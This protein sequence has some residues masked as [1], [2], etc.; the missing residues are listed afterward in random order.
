MEE[1][2]KFIVPD[3]YT[4]KQLRLKGW[5]KWRI[6]KYVQNRSIKWK[7]STMIVR[8][9]FTK[10]KELYISKEYIPFQDVMRVWIEKWDGEQ[11]ELIAEAFH[12][13]PLFALAECTKDLEKSEDFL[14]E[15]LKELSID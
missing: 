5:S 15:L 1:L 9:L 2:K 11:Y 8:K 7:K 10:Y 14:S 6:M 4:K 3:I 12:Q 13:D